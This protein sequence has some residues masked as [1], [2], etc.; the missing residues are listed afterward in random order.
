MYQPPVEGRYTAR[1]VCPS[2]LYG[3]GTGMSLA[4]PKNDVDCPLT[5]H[6]PLRYTPI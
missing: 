3:A 2:P 4:N 5:Y 6:A 1:S